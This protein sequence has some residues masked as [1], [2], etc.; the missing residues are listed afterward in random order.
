M[1]VLCSLL[2]NV[3][4]SAQSLII[5]AIA[6]PL[7]WSW[8][9]CLDIYLV[10]WASCGVPHQTGGFNGDDESMRGLVVPEKHL[11]NQYWRGRRNLPGY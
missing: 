7:T 10:V 3:A 2:R 8:G 11:S 6:R 5:A 1:G 9:H 4:L